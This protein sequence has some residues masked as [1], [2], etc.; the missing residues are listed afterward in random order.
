MC[1]RK[2]MNRF[3]TWRESWWKPTKQQN[4]NSQLRLEW[5]EIKKTN[6]EVETKWRWWY[7]VDE[8]EDVTAED[9]NDSKR[10]WDKT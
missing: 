10:G 5:E 9:N 7:D 6:G 2:M 3:L 8:E 4:F 1:G